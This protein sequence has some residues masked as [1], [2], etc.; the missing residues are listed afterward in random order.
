MV[1]KKLFKFKYL[2]IKKIKVNDKVLYCES[3]VI[4]TRDLTEAA[5]KGSKS[6]PVR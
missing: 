3:Y 4:V 6:H 2:W 5:K 1:N